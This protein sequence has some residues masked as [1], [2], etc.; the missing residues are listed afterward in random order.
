MTEGYIGD[1]H[2]WLSCFLQ[3]SHLLI[4]RIPTAAL[5]STQHLNTIIPVRHRRTTRL[6]LSS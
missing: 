5:N 4:Y 2:A 1:R 3:H 6:T